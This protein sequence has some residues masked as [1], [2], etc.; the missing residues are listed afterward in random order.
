MPASCPARRSV[1]GM[2]KRV[3]M[4]SFP[5]GV[6]EKVTDALSNCKA[7]LQ[8]GARECPIGARAAPD[9]LSRCC[10]FTELHVPT[11]SPRRSPRCSRNAPA[12]PFAA[13]VVAVPT[14]GMERWLTQHMSAVLGAT[15]ERA[16]GI[17]AN[18]LF[19]TPHRLTADA[20]AAAC[21]I[22]PARDPWLPERAVWPLLAIV[23][24]SLHE[25]WLT[26]LATYLGAARRRVVQA[27]AATQRRRPPRD[28]VRPL[29]DA[30]AGDAG[31]VAGRPAITTPSG[32]AAAP[33]GRVAGRA[34][35]PAA[36]AD[37]GPEPGRASSA[38]AGPADRRT[39]PGASCPSGSPCSG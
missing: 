27:V 25:P 16:D 12:D 32:D 15:P 18:V 34:V 37:R 28:A 14:R 38:G 26:A 3:A 11:D 2:W 22:D 36:R 33:R 24:E 1:V 19:P 17:C 9:T 35:A 8:L 5:R 23:D 20:A 31:G 6:A 7:K 30:P 21:E 13:D 4:R 39:G 29:R 10:M